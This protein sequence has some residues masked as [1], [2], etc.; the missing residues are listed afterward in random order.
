MA[1]VRVY[2]E[3]VHEHRE[4]F[5]GDL[6]VIPAGEFITMN[7]EDAVLFRSQF[8]PIM[9]RN[10]GASDDPRGFKMIRI[11]YDTA[12]PVDVVAKHEA[13]LLCQA[14]GFVAKT[15][16][17]LKVHVRTHVGQMVDETAR[18]AVQNGI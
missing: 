10:G 17:G 12:A 4:K 3:N 7:R 8:T 6:I 2:N 16:A 11:D 18:E 1:N 5:R 13:A 15:E 9:R 14:C